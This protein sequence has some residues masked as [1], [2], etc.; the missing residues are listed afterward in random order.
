MY[1]I[2]KE[3]EEIFWLGGADDERMQNLASLVRSNRR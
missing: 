3:R 1:S 2:L